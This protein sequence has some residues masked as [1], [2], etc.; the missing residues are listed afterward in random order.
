ML[1]GWNNPVA[2]IFWV[3]SVLSESRMDAEGGDEMEIVVR[4]SNWKRHVRNAIY[5][6]LNDK[7]GFN[8]TNTDKIVEYWNEIYQAYAKYFWQN[9]GKLDIKDWLTKNFNG[10]R[11]DFNKDYERVREIKNK[12]N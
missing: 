5:Q 6:F 3:L 1:G 11:K 12:T 8:V 10:E 9:N 2:P 4:D 7:Y